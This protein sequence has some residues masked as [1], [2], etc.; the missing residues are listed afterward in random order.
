MKDF[1]EKTALVIGG[2]G[3]IGSHIC[4]MLSKK[5]GKLYVHGGHDSKKF[6]SLIKTLSEENC[7]VQKIVYDFSEHGFSELD[8]SELTKIAK[9]SDILCVCHGP[10]LQKKIEEMDSLDWQKIALFDY[11]LPG[12][13]V[14]KTLSGMIEKKFGRIILFGGTGTA[15]RMEFK[16]NAAYAGAKTALGTLVE[17]VAAAY[18][19]FDI[20]CNAILPGFV[21]TEYNET[22]PI[23]E[24]MEVS[25]SDIS[26]S[27]K[28]LLENNSLNG[29]LLRVDKG[30]SPLF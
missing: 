14:S 21:K 22:F 10:F 4:K 9:T 16:T 8:K 7:E 18:A 27:V 1:S 25:P 3:G 24:G 28:F 29:V 30:W 13:F 19:K 17:S 20:T 11:A 23:P 26:E 6:D 5:C 15:H 12:F 2:S